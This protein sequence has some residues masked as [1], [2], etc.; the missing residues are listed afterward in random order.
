MRL[1]GVEV[2]R[3]N[4]GEKTDRMSATS[5]PGGVV[6]HVSDHVGEYGRKNRLGGLQGAAHAI[7]CGIHRLKRHRP[8]AT[9]YDKLAVRYEATV[10]VAAVNEWL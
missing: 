6:T 10:L 7:E 1:K 4:V 8:V 3:Q 9:R 5:C 2:N